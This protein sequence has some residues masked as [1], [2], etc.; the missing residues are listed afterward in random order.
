VF[1]LASSIGPTPPS[2][3]TRAAIPRNAEAVIGVAFES[4]GA[5]VDHGFDRRPT[6]SR[7]PRPPR[8]NRSQV[9]NEAASGTTRLSAAARR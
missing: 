4:L 2:H 8:A 3:S 7:S 9:S 5:D 6:V 1:P